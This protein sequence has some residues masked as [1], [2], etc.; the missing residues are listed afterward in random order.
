MALTFGVAGLILGHV[1]HEAGDGT[2]RGVRS[3]AVSRLVLV[4]LVIGLPSPSQ[5]KARR[6]AVLRLVHERLHRVLL[7]VTV[8]CEPGFRNEH[9]GDAAQ[10]GRLGKEGGFPE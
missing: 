6:L 9:P 2:H 7:D 10:H 3:R 4:L 1:H 5:F 8:E